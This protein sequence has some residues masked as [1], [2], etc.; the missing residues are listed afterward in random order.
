MRDNFLN[1]EEVAGAV[2]GRLRRQV[3]R[4]GP[5]DPIRETW[6]RI[7]RVPGVAEL[8]HAGDPGRP[9]PVIVPMLIREKD[10]VF[11]WFSTL[12]VF[13]ATGDVTLEELVI[14]CFF[15]GDDAT[16]AFAEDV[17][18]RLSTKKRPRKTTLKRRKRVDGAEPYS[19]H[20]S[21]HQA[22]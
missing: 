2:L 17:A 13:G 14:E 22:G 9:P 7:L 5:G 3:T 19:Q 21:H 18:S 1:W 8:D 10:Q 4:A 15:P 12:A 16:R 11:T 6:D 20:G